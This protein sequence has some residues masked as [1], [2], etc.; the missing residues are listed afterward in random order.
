MKL[1]VAGVLLSIVAVTGM[2]LAAYTGNA[3]WLILS[4]MCGYVVWGS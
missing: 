4:I 3:G 2:I 1:F